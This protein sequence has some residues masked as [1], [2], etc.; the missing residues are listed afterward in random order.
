MNMKMKRQFY[1]FKNLAIALTILV[2]SLSTSVAQV[3][4][5]E[6]LRE[7]GGYTVLRQSD[8][9][10][11]VIASSATAS[12]A[13]TSP[14]IW[15]RNTGEVQFLEYGTN[16]FDASDDGIIVGTFPDPSIVI[17]DKPVLSAGWYEDGAWHSLGGLP[18]ITIGGPSLGSRAGAIT[19]DGEYIAGYA[20]VRAGRYVPIVWKKN[21]SGGYSFHKQYDVGLKAAEG[22]RAWDISADGQVICGFEAKENGIWMPMIWTDSDQKVIPGDV[23]ANVYRNMLASINTNGT[24]SVGGLGVNGLIMYTDGQYEVIEATPFNDI[25]D[26]DICVGGGLIYKKNIGSWDVVKYMKKF[27]GVEIGGRVEQIMAISTNGK[28]LAGHFIEDGSGIKYPFAITIDGYPI[29]VAPDVVNTKLMTEGTSTVEIIWS[30]PVD[31]EYEILGYNVYRSDIPTPMNGQTLLEGMSFTDLSPVLDG[32]NCYSVTAS[33]KYGDNIVEGPKSVSSC[34]EVISADGC[35]SPKQLVQEVIYNKTV[36]LTWSAPIPNYGNI[37]KSGTSSK[38]RP[39]YFKSYKLKSVMNNNEGEF[40]SKGEVI[41]ESDGDFIYIL[42]NVFDMMYKYTIDG[43]FVE[44]FMPTS[45][46]GR[47][48]YYSGLT[49]YG[50]YFYSACYEPTALGSYYKIDMDAKKEIETIRTN[51]KESVERVTYIPTLNDGDGGFEVGNSYDGTSWFLDKSFNQIEGGLDDPQDI[52][53]LAYYNGKLYATLQPKLND[54]GRPIPNADLIVKVFDAETGKATGQYIDLKDY[55]TVKYTENAMLGGITVVKTSEGISCLSI[56]ISDVTESKLVLLQLEQMEGLLGY[57]V[58]KNGEKINENT[59]EEMFYT[60]DITT[61]GTYT[62]TVTALFE[63][64]CESNKSLPVTVKIDEIGT[65]NEPTDVE[66]ELIRNNAQ[67]TWTAPKAV[68]PHKLLGFNVYR[69]DLKINNTLV[70][71]NFYTD[72]NLEFA[73]YTYSIEAFYSNSCLSAKS[74]SATVS[75]E[76]NNLVAPPTNLAVKIDNSTQATLSWS[77][78]AIGDYVTKR[79][80]D[81]GFEWAVGEDGGGT[82]YVGSKWDAKDLDLYF[83]YTL[84]DVEFYPTLD[85]PHTFI[86]YVDGAEV[87]RQVLPSVKADAFNL[88]KLEEPILIER[89][90]ELMVA[91]MVQ[92]QAGETPIGADKTSKNSGKGDLMSYDGVNWEASYNDHKVKANWAITIRLTPYSIGIEPAKATENPVYEVNPNGNNLLFLDNLSKSVDRS[93]FENKEV[94]GYNIYKGDAKL[95]TVTTNTFSVPIKENVNSCYTVSALFSNNRVSEKTTEACVFGECQTVTDLVGKFTADNTVNLKWSELTGEPKKDVEIKYHKGNTEGFGFS[96]DVEQTYYALISANPVDLAKYEKLKL[97][98]IEALI[99][100]ECEVSLVVFQDGVEV[101][102]D[103]LSDIAYGE[104]KKYELPDGGI[105]VDGTKNL[106]VGLKIT[107]DAKV[108]AIGIDRGPANNFRSNILSS[109]GV[110]LEALSVVTNGAVVGSWNISANLESLMPSNETVV[111]YRIFRDGVQ[112]GR[113]NQADYIDTQIELERE[114]SYHVVTAWST[115]CE[116]EVSNAVNVFTKLTSIDDLGDNN[117]TVY[118]N[119]AKNRV[120]IN[121]QYDAL[122]MYNSAGIMVLEQNYNSNYVDVEIFYKGIYVI[123]LLRENNVINRTKLIITK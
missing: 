9:G 118:P 100:N 50:D 116:S 87:S 18:G 35:F 30:K 55:T 84:T 70:A 73:E 111:E 51:L 78:P 110:N 56:L 60:E 72:V 98:S 113:S 91:Y 36:N 21:T 59:L 57:N 74:E 61:P 77:T 101:Y 6:V 62:Y 114:Y 23:A 79:W 105:L 19:P 95:S 11:F 96:W 75:V 17:D 104:F 93:I 108:A 39:P 1:C 85:I 115:G 89:G 8:N 102:S 43:E 54:E 64:D 47:Q 83:G 32:A 71:N 34:I 97:K 117:I 92:H 82:V 52:F 46:P 12:G 53:D 48:N 2:G 24:K 33:Y 65:C 94:T 49:K 29:A 123:E 15:D 14:G 40:F 63:Q 37:S 38:I 44:N 41:P 42:D 5:F 31:I 122:R 22:G 69:D 3:A 106:V 120:N 58:Y 90:K 121:G 7:L 27:Y 103:Y 25:S 45:K 4:K 66:I 67:V 80:Y 68:L 81:G 88:L 112:I 26:N 86:V 107:A 10:R 119:P 109:D 16:A 99:L 13:S 76:G 20:W 28:Y